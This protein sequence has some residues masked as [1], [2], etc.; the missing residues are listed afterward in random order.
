MSQIER[1]CKNCRYRLNNRIC[2]HPDSDYI[3]CVMSIND[4]CREFAPGGANVMA[5]TS[6]NQ[7]KRGVVCQSWKT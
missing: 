3:G 2:S 5:K 1:K 4:W 6:L 7:A